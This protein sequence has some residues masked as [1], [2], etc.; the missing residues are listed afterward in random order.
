MR[1]GSTVFFFLIKYNQNQRKDLDCV[2]KSYRIK[3]NKKLTASLRNESKSAL[4][5]AEFNVKIWKLKKITN[6]F[7]FLVSPAWITAGS[8]SAGCSRSSVLHIWW[9]RQKNTE[10]KKKRSKRNVLTEWVTRRVH[11]VEEC[12][13]WSQRT[14]FQEKNILWNSH[15]H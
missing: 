9:S 12:Q 7:Y 8:L 14:H 11:Q 6:S 2:H 3:Q 15:K 13:G 10:W 1:E 4:V 5:S